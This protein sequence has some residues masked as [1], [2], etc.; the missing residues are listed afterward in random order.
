MNLFQLIINTLCF[1]YVTESLPMFRIIEQTSSQS[2]NETEVKDLEFS[3]KVEIIN[4]TVNLTYTDPFF[5]SSLSKPP[6][7]AN[8][9]VANTTTA[10]ITN[11]NITIA[12]KKSNKKPSNLP[13]I[14]DYNTL[15]SA[16]EDLLGKYW[17]TLWKDNTFIDSTVCDSSDTAPR[18]SIWSLAVALQSF[19]DGQKLKQHDYKNNISAIFTAISGYWNPQYNLYGSSGPDAVPYVDDNA[20]LASALIEAYEQTGV[21]DYLSKGQTLVEAM[22]QQWNDKYGGVT[23][24]LGQ[25]YIATISTTES[26]LAAIRLYKHKKKASYLDFAEK[27]MDWIRRYMWDNSTNLLY[28]GTG[29][30]TDT[31][32]N[33]ELTYHVGTALSLCVKLYRETK[34]NKWKDYADLL[35]AAGINRD[36]K[37]YARE[38][39]MQFRYW[40]DNTAWTQLLAY[41]LIDYVNGINASEAVINEVVREATYLHNFGQGTDGL[42]FGSLSPLAEDENIYKKWVDF[43]KTDKKSE[44]ENKLFCGSDPQKGSTRGL[45]SQAAASI[46]FL[47]TAVGLKKYFK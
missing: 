47:Q 36:L 35:A 15:K 45:I 12:S 29:N 17:N 44:V 38:Y 23:W 30:L 18:A 39:D 33:V 13:S 41:G 28:D 27:S 4:N 11:L 5:N 31:D 21:K 43:T 9:T 6:T 8:I 20:Q 14:N 34:D 40:Y 22:M 46:F 37:I 16:G 24:E 32:K 42:Y 19:V 3:F 10:N 2:D 25:P 1:V 7:I 26:A